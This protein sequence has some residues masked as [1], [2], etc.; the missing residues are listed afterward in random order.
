MKSSYTSLHPL[1]ADELRIILEAENILLQTIPRLA[2]G[3]GSDLV[4]ELDEALLEESER[5]I[6]RMESAFRSL[7]DKLGEPAEGR[8]VARDSQRELAQISSKNRG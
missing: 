6:I 3:V 8:L 4:C 1:V 2:L 5:Q 7:G